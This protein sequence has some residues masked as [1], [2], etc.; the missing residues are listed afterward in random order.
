MKNTYIKNTAILFVSMAITK[1]V[2]AVF[3][4][5]LAN[6]LGGTGMG[7][8]STAYALYSPV[9]A[10]AAAG[11]PTV[12][13]RMTAQ[14]IVMGRKDTAQAV[15][16]TAL[17]L[18]SAIGVVGMIIIMLL[19]YPF[20]MYFAG[21]PE[22]TPAL[23]AIAPA[24]LL[25]CI[26]CVL[27]GYYEGLNEV[28]PSAVAAV[29]ESAS[30]AVFGLAMSYGIVYF[31]K[32]RYEMGLDIF[33]ISASSYEEAHNA[34]LPYAAAAAILAVSI[35]ELIGLLSLVIIDRKRKEDKLPTPHGY[36][37]KRT[38]SA[39][40]SQV[41]PIAAAS[42]VMNCV[43]FVDLLTVTNSI[44][45]SIKNNSDYF[46]KVYPDAINAS[47][48]IEG[49]ANFMYGSYTGIAMSLFMLIPSFACM[50]EKTS[51]PEIA[52]AYEK[53]DYN[54]IICHI[55]RMLTTA[56]AIGFPACFGAAALGEP[57][58]RLLYPSRTA[59]VGIC[60][61]P[62]TILCMSGFLM[63]LS[64]SMFGVMQAIGKAHIPL[65]LMSIS[66]GVKLL[67]NP[68]LISIPQLNIAG[69]AIASSF[70][71]LIT[72]V[73]SIIILRKHLGCK[74]GIFKCSIAPAVCGAL[75]A[76]TAFFVHNAANN[77]LPSFVCVILAVASGAIVYLLL[78]IS[79]YVFVKNK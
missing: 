70:S 42:L 38:A 26:A 57:I 18:F 28:T 27:R 6:V 74:L 31:A 66:V 34:A 35:S 79:T 78:L 64:S 10:L 49:L 41:L 32:H 2:G 17:K 48:G 7:Y 67:V 13:M 68:F 77:Q 23:I 76:V 20:A 40:L 33:G 51:A 36:S 44:E 53:K 9:L 29:T 5:P 4:I 73:C 61:P 39:L 15:K 47:G 69:A 46:A 54:V 58:L 3:K 8:F 1:V 30:R 12:M 25:C 63:I 55:N 71:Y 11:V 45:S 37:N 59:E 16:S 22:S 43:S 60:I 72:A 50:A 62:F 56:A 21:S 24:V 52:A 65:I 19:A 75:C 14:N